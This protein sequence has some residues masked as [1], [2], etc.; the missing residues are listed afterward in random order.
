MRA[1]LLNNSRALLKEKLTIRLHPRAD[2]LASSSLSDSN[3]FA[4]INM[5]ASN[6]ISPRHGNYDWEDESASDEFDNNNRDDVS[7]HSAISCD[8]EISE[9]YTLNGQIHSSWSSK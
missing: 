4:M 8:H 5:P 1:A 2:A 7:L 6:E 3:L 9:K